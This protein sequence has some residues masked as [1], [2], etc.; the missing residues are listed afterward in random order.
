MKASREPSTFSGPPALPHRAP[1]RINNIAGI[2]QPPSGRIS[3][4]HSISA[5]LQHSPVRSRDFIPPNAPPLLHPAGKILGRTKFW[6]GEVPPEPQTSNN[7]HLSRNTQTTSTLAAKLKQRPPS[8]QHSP[9][10]HPLRYPSPAASAI[11]KVC[12]TRSIFS[13]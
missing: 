11:R 3:P 13:F 12:P 2:S 5:D 7:L 6:E 9:G 10:F 1:V 4:P 8:P